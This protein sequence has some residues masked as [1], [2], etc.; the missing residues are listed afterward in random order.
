MFGR[1]SGKKNIVGENKRIKVQYAEV[2][3][4]LGQEP[5]M[6]FLLFYFTFQ[7]NFRC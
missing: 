6:E 4:R 2:Q 5:C 3:V 7:P 1:K